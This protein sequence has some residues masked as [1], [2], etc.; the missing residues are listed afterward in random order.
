MQSKLT[1]RLTLLRMHFGV[2]LLTLSVL[3][4]VRIAQY[5]TTYQKLS[6]HIV[7]K[8]TPNATRNK[9]YLLV[10]AVG[11]MSQIVPKSNC[12]TRALSLQYLLGLFGHE[13]VIRVGV[14]DAPPKGFEAHAWVLYGN[15]VIIGH[16]GE[17]ITRFTPITDLKP[18]H[19]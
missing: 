2:L 11:R 5:F 3:V 15:E 16:I 4:F 7:V 17:D 8:A 10:W 18:R 14:A 19:Q 1:R 13:S 6:N 12:L 9:V